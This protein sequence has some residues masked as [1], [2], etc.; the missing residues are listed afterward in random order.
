MVS[1]SIATSKGLTCTPYFV[2]FLLPKIQNVNS[3]GLQEKANAA[4]VISPVQTP[5]LIIIHT[6]LRCPDMVCIREY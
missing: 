6:R 4:E 2:L 3:I 1:R 5:Q